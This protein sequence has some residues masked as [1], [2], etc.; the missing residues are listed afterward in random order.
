M[1]K[2]RIIIS[3]LS[4]VILGLVSVACDQLSSFSKH[5]VVFEDNILLEGRTSS[6]GYVNLMDYSFWRNNR[7]RIEEITGVTVQYQVTQNQTPA[8]LTAS[9]YFGEY[10][11]SVYLGSASLGAMQTTGMLTLSISGSYTQLADLIMEKD[12]FWYAVQGNVDNAYVY[13]EPVRITITGTFD[14]P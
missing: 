10:Y 1:N 7:D 8:D 2:T 9:F 11:P 3:L 5:E 12:A 6:E 14:I 4:I 13:F